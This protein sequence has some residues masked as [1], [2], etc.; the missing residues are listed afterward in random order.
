M[1]HYNA[2]TLRRFV[3]TDTFSETESAS[4]VT[5]SANLT[6]ISYIRAA[7]NQRPPA[8]LGVCGRLLEVAGAALCC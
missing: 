4:L 3:K 7:K 2:L 1:K 8:D 6:Y 5:K